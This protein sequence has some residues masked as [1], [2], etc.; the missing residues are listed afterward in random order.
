MDQFALF[1]RPS[2]KARRT[3]TKLR[4]WAAERGGDSTVVVRGK[5]WHP[6]GDWRDDRAGAL[7]QPDAR[8]TI[9]VSTWIAACAKFTHADEEARKAFVL[10]A[11]D[12]SWA[13]E[14]LF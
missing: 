7:P 2:P 10:D 5:L 8:R 11:M 14:R 6:S 4:E 13:N 3:T 9:A 12:K 1:S